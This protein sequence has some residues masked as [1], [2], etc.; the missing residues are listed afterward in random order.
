MHIHLSS[1]ETAEEHAIAAYTA[2][3]SSVLTS[4]LYAKSVGAGKRWL[5]WEKALHKAKFRMADSGAHTIRTDAQYRGG[6]DEDPDR[7]QAEYMTWLHKVRARKLIDVWVELDIGIALGEKWVA[8]HRTKFIRA[9]LGS[10]LIQVWHSREH[11]WDYWKFLVA[12]SM[13]PG[14]SRYVAIEGRSSDRTELDY[15]R[16]IDYAR[17]HEVRVHGFKLTNVKK[18][19]LAF[20]FYSVD[21]R[22]WATGTM[23]GTALGHDALGWVTLNKTAAKK[24]PVWGLTG[25]P[26]RRAKYPV[27]LAYLIE[28]ARLWVRLEDHVTRYWAQKGIHWAA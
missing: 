23:F 18:D 16:F 15:S 22:T 2:G 19:L 17:K 10:G 20:P 5:G 25:V 28:C 3:A 26:P 4:F 12:E 11:D 14:R 1:I 7:V 9:G 6:S 24:R 27:R 21:S 13:R 8:A